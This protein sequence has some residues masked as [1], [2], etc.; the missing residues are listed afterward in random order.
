MYIQQLSIFVENRKGKMAEITGELQSHNIDI[1]ALSIADTTDYGILRLIVNDPQK[2]YTLLKESGFAV[3]LTDVI[4][5]EIPDQPGGL[6]SVVQVLTAADVEIEYMY[7]FLNP[8]NG[9]AFVII[10][11]EDNERSANV[12]KKAGIPMISNEQVTSI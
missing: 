6:N 8:K 5:V 7:A 11:V 12:L 3:S 9:A 2:A 10:R 4:A 1:R